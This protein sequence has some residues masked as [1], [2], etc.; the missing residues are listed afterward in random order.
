MSIY[1]VGNDLYT[2]KKSFDFVG[3]R[4]IWFTIAVVAIVLSLASLIFRGLN[5]GV[6]FTGGSQFTVSSTSDTSE[7]PAQKVFS[8]Y[9]GDDAV[10]VSALGD[11]SVRVQITKEASQDAKDT[12][13]SDQ[14]SNAQVEEIK[15]KLADAYGVKAEDVTSTYVGPSWGQDISTKAL[16]GFIVF[17]VLAA[18]GLTLYFR[19]WRNA[20]G[21]IL[22]LFNDLVVTV[23]I[24]S[25]FGFEVTPASVIGLLTI[26][27]YSLYDTVVVFDKVREN[28]E[29]LLKQDDYTFAEST[30]LAVNQTLIRTLNTSVTSLLPVASILF[31][32]VWLL[33]AATL[34]DLALV[35]FVGLILSSLSSMF[36]AAP[37]AV[38]LTETS[39]E[40]KEHTA[41]VLAKREARIAERQ[42]RI[43]AG[44]DV[45][46]LEE[47]PTKAI[48]SVPGQHLGNKAQPKRKKRK[49]K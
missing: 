48:M 41:K 7:A 28:T 2:G 38:A 43:D 11:S 40:I 4:K 25:I 32:G 33:G 46:D 5:L 16:R 47:I 12:S 36:I 39:P 15:A 18:L 14:L 37:L 22:A 20:A 26:L 3:K 34:R 21:A 9:L 44:E 6:E 29:K 27:A 49:K 8:E 10:R 35:M 19:T 13:D 23:G 24:Y 45:E 17:V 1:S 31:I 30:N 42:A